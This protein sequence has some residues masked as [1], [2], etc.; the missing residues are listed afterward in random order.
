M[1]DPQALLDAIAKEILEHRP[2]GF[3]VCEQATNLVPRRLL[4]TVGRRCR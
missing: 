4:L 3:A 1:S 2:C